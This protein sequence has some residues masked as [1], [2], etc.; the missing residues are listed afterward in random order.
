MVQ[1]RPTSK[2][3]PDLSTYIFSGNSPVRFI[4]YDGRDFGIKI[5]HDTKSIIIVVDV[6]AVND[7]ALEQF[8]SAS[9]RW[10]ETEFKVDGYSVSFEFSTTN[11]K[12]RVS[13]A[14]IK[15]YYPTVSFERNN[16][17][18]NLRR[19]NGY[20]KRALA[21]KF[22]ALGIKE[23]QNSFHGDVSDYEGALID[24]GVAESN[25]DRKGLLIL[26]R[27]E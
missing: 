16:G 12:M 20:R 8:E 4:D 3:Y 21:K 27:V 23:L 26:I 6:I 22:D 24:V 11:A 18:D 2:K 14:E 1:C 13:N 10:S 17:V 7:I 5:D 9:S 19:L 15:K 25:S